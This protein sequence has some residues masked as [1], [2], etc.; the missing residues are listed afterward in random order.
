MHPAESEIR[1]HNQTYS[2][3][4]SES[5]RCS[6]QAR[7]IQITLFQLHLTIFS[8]FRAVWFSGAVWSRMDLFLPRKKIRYCHKEWGSP[9]SF[10]TCALSLSPTTDVAWRQNSNLIILGSSA[11]GIVPGPGSMP[12]DFR[13]T[14]VSLLLL[15]PLYRPDHCPNSALPEPNR[16]PLSPK[17]Q[18]YSSID[19]Q[20]AHPI[21]LLKSKLN[22]HLFVLVF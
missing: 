16:Q 11:E 8:V 7:Q 10:P 1:S 20:R 12:S 21:S 5:Y 3:V 18:T 14:D 17:L 6:H 2:Y 13:C 4:C 9:N 15:I 19:M 22:S